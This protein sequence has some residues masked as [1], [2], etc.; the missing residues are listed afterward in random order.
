M[1][2]ELRLFL[3]GVAM[4]LFF[5]PFCYPQNLSWIHTMGSTDLD[6]IVSIDLDPFYNI[7]VGGHFRDTV[8]MNPGSGTDIKI[9][10]ASGRAQVVSSFDKMGNYR[11]SR[12]LVAPN[13]FNWLYSVGVGPV[14]EVVVLGTFQTSLDI[15]TGT[16]ITTLNTATSSNYIAKYNDQGALKWVYP[17]G[18][19][20]YSNPGRAFVLK[21][22]DILIV[23]AIMLS[24]ARDID[25]GPGVHMY[26]PSSYSDIA[27]IRLDSM[28]NQKWIK[29]YPANVGSSLL[30]FQLEEDSNQNLFMLF[31]FSDTTNF[32][33]GGTN[34][35]GT[36]P[37][38]GS[39]M[40]LLK[41]DSAG[42]F[43]AG[44]PFYTNGGCLGYITLDSAGAV[45]MAGQVSSGVMDL[46]PG[47]GTFNTATCSS[48]QAF[49]GKY[50]ASNLS[51]IWAKNVSCGVS[52]GFYDVGW[53]E[54]L[55]RL[56][57]HGAG[58]MDYDPGP[59]YA[60][61]TTALGAI[62]ML[63]SNGNFD[64]VGGIPFRSGTGFLLTP[65]LD[66]FMADGFFG[67]VDADPSSSVQN[68]ISSGSEDIFIAK[69][70]VTSNAISGNVYRDFNLNGMFDTG[71]LPAFDIPVQS[72]SPSWFWSTNSAGDYQAWV[73]VGT[74]TLD[75]PSPPLYYTVA[76]A[77]RN[78][79][80]S[81]IQSTSLNQDFALRPIAGI[82]D[83]EIDIYSSRLRPGFMG[84]QYLW[85]QNVGTDTSAGVFRHVIDP[86]VSYVSAIPVPDSMVADTIYWSYSNLGPTRVL[87][88]SI[89]LAVST[90][91]P[92]GAWADFYAEVFTVR[93]DS[94][95]LNNKDSLEIA[96]TGSYD[97]NDKMSE[98]SLNISP[99]AVAA[100]EWI[101]YTIRFQNTG[102]DTAFTVRIRDTLD[103]NLDIG[104]IQMMHSSHFNYYNLSGAGNIEWVFPNI[105]LPD[106]GTN[107]LGSNGY[108]KYRIKAD[109]SLNAGDFMDN[110]A[111]IY[112]D[113]NAPVITNTTHLLVS[114]SLFA[115]SVLHGPTCANDSAAQIEIVDNLPGT[116]E[117]SLDSISYQ[118]S[119]IFGGLAAGNFPVF[120]RD[121]SGHVATIVANIPPADSIR[122]DSVQVTDVLCFG[123]AGTLQIQVSGGG[124]GFSYSLDSA[125]FVANPSFSGLN[126]GNYAVYVQD[127]TGCTASTSGITITAPTSPI[128]FS[129][130]QETPVSCAGASDGELTFSVTGGEGPYL[131]SIN[132]VTY[133]TD[134]TFASLPGGVY[135]L[136][137][138]D[139][140][141]CTTYFTGNTLNEPA[142]ISF[143]SYFYDSP[144]CA[145]DSN[146]NLTVNFTGG[147]GG[148]LYSLDSV[149][150]SPAN[151]FYGL[152][153][154]IYTAYV[155]DSVGC[156]AA[157]PWLGISEPS[158]LTDNGSLSTDVSCA[159]GTDGGIS[160]NVTGGN[161][162]YQYS[163]DSLSWFSNNQF[164]GLSAGT[165]TLYATDSSGCRTTVPGLVVSEPAPLTDAGSFVTSVSCA[166]GMNGSITLNVAGGNGSYEFSQNSLNW[167]SN[168]Q[169]TALAAGTYSFFVRDALGCLTVLNGF[170]V[171]EPAPLVDNG[172]TVSMPACFGEASGGITLH[173]SGG[174]QPYSFSLNGGP[175]TA[176]SSFA[177]LPAGS[178]SATV[179]DSNGCQLTPVSISISA[180]DSLVL[181]NQI[182]HAVG[183]AN[184][185]IQ[186]GASGGTPPLQYSFNGGAFLP[187][188][189]FTNL[190]PGDYIVV[191]R[192]ANG[193]ELTDTLT[194]L[195]LT[196]TG[197][198]ISDEFGL[199]VFPNP[200]IGELNLT[201]TGGE[202]HR[203]RRVMVYNAIGEKVYVSGPME[204]STCNI[205]LG[206]LANGT[207][208]V[209]I[210]TDK[211]IYTRKILVKD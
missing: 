21:N 97:P 67:T 84:R 191:L 70:R 35:T 99:A 88:A 74:T 15:E 93:N 46:N 137:V 58:N 122:I 53:C 187:D 118:A 142:P 90:G 129:G 149:S 2:K 51:F 192:D 140:R 79:S 52:T 85:I 95:P 76:P 80:F 113:Y 165:Y 9:S 26:T 121:S 120:I 40:M 171:S 173:V 102:N 82:S 12:S 103:A 161:G 194:V 131:Y 155:L 211:G 64:R 13:N 25:P 198:V 83:V 179:T 136:Y 14:G 126:A 186:L 130:F 75:I 182:T 208:L 5:Q 57:L 39:A 188:S 96:F 11:W 114:S 172:A 205:D 43:Q 193:C 60:Y 160:A 181:T 27:I 1:K 56:L 34:F 41:L 73:D 47:P 77:S 42:D 86:R 91:A 210:E 119:P 55:S 195:S 177:N 201:A 22:K 23:D 125:T 94:T 199:N 28:G 54:P 135:T 100:G 183:G 152:P 31:G 3:V 92:L 71:D 112:F 133:G 78:V 117:Y 72:Q 203:I 38:W 209:N 50:S 36:P 200:T 65:E 10:S 29:T 163:I 68:I 153:A 162:G 138:E 184:G 132:A 81:A 169:V 18:T 166:G 174:I 180:P 32:D 196:S 176:D 115:A 101:E 127:T 158:P 17:F 105:L 19:P 61:M 8:D 168:N 164:Q 33:P 206:E 106:S 104:S 16:G 116:Y 66:L 145:G 109:S 107:Q 108:V 30:N 111:A 146:G 124:G 207:Y 6:E 147:N 4:L 44:A 87:L 204:C 190:S 156:A 89:D 24:G 154:G 175:S 7:V 151:Q 48:N 202:G 98:P 59:G 134:S 148:F 143:V 45:Y 185:I 150:F 141:G 49:V 62:G 189:V 63:D 139:N 123:G 197:E 110:T 128:S 69:Y 178:Y 20:G 159:G 170:V 167:F 144:V 37:A 157:V